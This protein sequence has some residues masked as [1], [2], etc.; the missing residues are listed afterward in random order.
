M[1]KIIEC[2]YSQI[3][4][5]Y[6]EQ[7][8]EVIQKCLNKNPDKRPSIRDLMKNEKLMEIKKE[9]LN[10][11]KPLSFLPSKKNILKNS[12]AINTSIINDTSPEIKVV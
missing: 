7:L 4:Q 2:E 3:N 12:L 11:N 5:V 6:S 1:K 8:R 10:K 9:F